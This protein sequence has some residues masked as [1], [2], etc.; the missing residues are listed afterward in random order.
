MNEN[1]NTNNDN[2]R[3][4]LIGILLVAPIYIIFF[5][6]LFTFDF[7]NIESSMIVPFLM[8]TPIVVGIALSYKH[9]KNKA[10]SV[11]SFSVLVFLF[12][13]SLAYYYG[14]VTEDSGWGR[15]GAS[16]LWIIN[17][18]I[19]RILACVFY[20]KIVGWRKV[21][22]FISIEILCIASPFLLNLL[23]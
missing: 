13:A 1:I 22:L 15:V 9:F 14:Y 3:K 19:C 5:I 10:S 12:L 7:K 16:F 23:A 18:A 8:Y 11:I 20:G 17:T 6:I 21:L 2:I 4:N